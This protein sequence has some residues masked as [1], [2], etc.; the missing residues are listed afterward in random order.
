MPACLIGLQVNKMED[1]VLAYEECIYSMYKHAFSY[2]GPVISSQ[3]VLVPC[4]ST[5]KL[6]RQKPFFPHKIFIPSVPPS[7][8]TIILACFL[9]PLQP[10]RLPARQS[11]SNEKQFVQEV[12]IEPQGLLLSL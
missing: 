5:D 10:S 4:H 3:N 2:G 8:P 9:T 6:L 7:F 1:V 12:R 11:T